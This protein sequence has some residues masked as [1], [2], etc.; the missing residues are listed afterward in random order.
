MRNRTHFVLLLSWNVTEDAFNVNDPYF[1]TTVRAAHLLVQGRVWWLTIAVPSQQLYNYSDVSDIIIYKIVPQGERVTPM[2]YPLF[3]QVSD[4]SAASC[5]KNSAAR[6][7][8]AL[9]CDPRWGKDTM[10]DNKTTVV[11]PCPCLC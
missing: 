8:L 6:Q 4:I 11:R 7:S 3:K 1:N 9:Q 2:N 10:E 5:M